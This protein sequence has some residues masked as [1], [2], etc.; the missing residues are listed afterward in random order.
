MM[1]SSPTRSMSSSRRS[2][3]TRIVVSPLAWRVFATLSRAAAGA[4]LRSR[5]FV[6]LLPP[7]IRLG[8]SAD[9]LDGEVHIVDDEDE[10]ILDIGARCRRGQACDPGNV[11]LL[12]V[13]LG[14]WRN[15][16]RVSAS[17]DLAGAQ[18]A[19]LVQQQKRIGAVGQDVALEAHPNEPG[20]AFALRFGGRLGMV[21][22]VFAPLPAPQVTSWRRA[23]MALPAR[24][25]GFIG[26]LDKAANVVLGC[27][28]TQ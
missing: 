9:A 12:G 24:F 25:V 3:W 23:R 6:A 18:C 26:A 16:G 21:W 28:R 22:T 27:E 8:L 7:G 5:S 4:A 15:F 11:A 2:A 10:H 20:R 13:E 19:E 17:P 14:Q 1:T